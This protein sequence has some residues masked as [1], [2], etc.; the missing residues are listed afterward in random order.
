MKKLLLL[1]I[2]S[3]L[4]LSFTACSESKEKSPSKKENTGGS[5]SVSVSVDNSKNKEEIFNDEEVIKNL[6][7]STYTWKEGSYSYAAIIVKNNSK[8]DCNLTANIVFKDGEGNV[9]GADDGYIYALEKNTEACIIVS[10]ETEFASFDYTYEAEKSDF[11]KAASSSILCEASTT[12]DK[13]ILTFKN[14]GEKEIDSINYHVLFM[15]GENVIDNSYGFISDLA[16]GATKT[17][18]ANFYNYKK[19][20]DNVKI[21]YSGYS[22]EW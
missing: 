22:T 3:L 20:F 9:I 15:S 12:S 16:P 8:M 17:E 6:T 2:T 19:D 21:Y 4:V 18:E 11:Y 1:A 5:G 14:N 7:T 10:N 13:A